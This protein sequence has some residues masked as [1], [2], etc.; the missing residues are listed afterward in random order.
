MENSIFLKEY[1]REEDNSLSINKKLGLH[2]K[3]SKITGRKQSIKGFFLTSQDDTGKIGYSDPEGYLE[4]DDI[5][6]CAIKNPKEGDSLIFTKGKWRIQ[7]EIK[8][9]KI[10]DIIN[11]SRSII[12]IELLHLEP[13]ASQ[14]F[15]LKGEI[16]RLPQI[17]VSSYDGEGIPLVY[18][19]KSNYNIGEVT[20]KIHNIGS[21]TL[22]Q[23]LKLLFIK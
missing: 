4:L 16:N 18:I 3:P 8:T 11:E 14:E 6:D 13:S 17:S 23:S 10:N 5:Y 15:N 20:I 22:T 7:N 19:T 1:H 2:I 12:H 9:Y 21:R